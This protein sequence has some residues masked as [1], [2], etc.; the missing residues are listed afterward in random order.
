MRELRLAVR[1]LRRQPVFLLVAVL[2]IAIGVGGATAIFSLLYEILL[3]PLPYRDPGR[4]V[5]VWNSYPRM[6]MPRAAVSIPDYLDRI[7]QAPSVQSAALF[8]TRT[9]NLGLGDRPQQLRAIAVTPSFFATLGR[10]PELGRGF[11]DAEA[12]PGSDRVVVLTDGLWRSQFGGDPAVV[13][14]DIRLSG[15]PYRVVGVLPA[16][17]E[18]PAVDVTLLV[19]FAFT[20]AQR[21]DQERGREFSQM[22]ARLAPGASIAS[23]DTEM[24][25]IVQRTVDRLPQRRAFAEQSGF[26]G[27]AV[28]IREQLVGDV[29]TP[30]YL[31][32]AGVL[33][34]LLIACVNV[35]NLMLMRASERHRELAL[36]TA[37]G[38]RRLHLLVQLLSEGL[39]IAA[40][41]AAGGVLIGL[42]LRRGL[43]AF[44]ADQL[45]MPAHAAPYLVMA[46]AG[47]ALSL[48]ITLV[49]GAVPAV[50]VLR[51]E[52]AGPINDESGR[53]AGSRRSAW[54]QSALVII[55]TALALMLLVTAGLLLKS[56]MRLQGTSPGFSPR[57][58]MTATLSLPAATYPTPQARAQFWSRLLE[59]ARAI[60]GVTD[61]GLTSNI[62][63]SGNV[64]S[65][66]YS[67]VG[68]TPGPGEVA[69]H[70]RQE[71]VGG[72]YF[73]AMQIPLR[74]GRTFDQRDGPDAP[75][76]VVVDEFLVQ[77]YFRGRSP[78]GQQ[79]R[80]GGPDSP[81]ITIVGVVGTINAIDLAQPVDKERLYYPVTQQSLATMSVVLRTAV[82]PATVVAPLRQAVRGIDADQAIAT[83]RT[84]DEWIARSTMTRRAP[85]VLFAAF[86]GVAL[87]L[88]AIGTYGVL[89]FGVAQRT[90][91]LGIRQ[92][93]GADRPAILA[94]ILKQGLGRVGLGAV[95]G[96]VGGLALSQLLRSQLYAVTPAD[97]LV[98]GV[99]TSLLLV[100]TAAA[101]LIPAWRATQLAPSDA[102]REG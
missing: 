56:F 100:V 102:L 20:P 65:G 42:G 33:V 78:L 15:E 1:R 64:S 54:T 53:S 31:L 83:V 11:I 50:A 34:V 89:A 4:L 5:F 29:R 55:E 44:T 72:D 14:R 6:A 86:A 39:V 76:V 19:P 32:Q 22:I 95:A 96:L 81:A 48:V 49:I 13:G 98:A 3:R 2:T 52:A 7:E 59:T 90:R 27:Y 85:M 58:V 12:E 37:L 8:T 36:R 35:T 62:P 41:G 38:A 57:G 82:A 93:L 73:Q 61:A 84:M 63:L 67:I 97:P 51:R 70:G 87:L 99:A 30:L 101:C 94:L 28:P 71:T 10:T 45:P 69:P 68:Y 46:L 88:A 75:P 74:A 47:A 66:S 43:L 91:E 26:R 92:A 9:F 18:L 24:T 16:D 23:L 79:I 21:A 40:A 25:T 60:P 17:F 77:R 80:R